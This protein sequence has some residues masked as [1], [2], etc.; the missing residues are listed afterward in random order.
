MQTIAWKKITT[1]ED[2]PKYYKPVIIFA[3][4][5]IHYDWHRLSDGEY[6]YYGSL[7]TDVIIPG[8]EVTHYAELIKPPK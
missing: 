7:N 5:K 8:E 1:R 2:K 3:N 4:N 6:E